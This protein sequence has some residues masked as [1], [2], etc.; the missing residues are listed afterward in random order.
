MRL[1][2]AISH[3][4][5]TVTQTELQYL[6]ACGEGLKGAP[7]QAG[8]DPPVPDCHYGAI[9]IQVKN[10]VGGSKVELAAGPMSALDDGFGGRRPIDHI[11]ILLQ[12][13][14]CQTLV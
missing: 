4:L 10:K 13:A 12:T 1:D 2:C 7:N 8:W 6:R 5:S 11:S 14:H 3:T 9:V